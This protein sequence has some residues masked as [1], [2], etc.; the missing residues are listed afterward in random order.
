M[1]EV[2]DRVKYVKFNKE[3]RAGVT[4]IV[5]D[6][7]GS[8]SIIFY[9]IEYLEN[10]RSRFPISRVVPERDLK[11]DIVQ[12]MVWDRAREREK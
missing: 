3:Y 1:Y 10:T 9:T 7:R 11:K 5:R 4:G 12:Q 2:G 8:E 6:A